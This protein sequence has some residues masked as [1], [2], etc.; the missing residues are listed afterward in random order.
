MQ[1]VDTEIWPISQA[2]MKA[3]AERREPT[4]L[5]DAHTIVVTTMKHPTYTSYWQSVADKHA[6]L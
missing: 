4:S 6:R 1:S 2:G 5:G 3:S